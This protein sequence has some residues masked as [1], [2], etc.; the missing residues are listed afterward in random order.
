MIRRF[1][2]GNDLMISATGVQV[3]DT[4]K[5]GQK[6]TIKAKP[7]YIGAL[8]LDSA[9]VRVRDGVAGIDSLRKLRWIQTGMKLDAQWSIPV[10]YSMKPGSHTLNISLDPFRQINLPTGDTTVESLVSNN[11]VSVSWILADT[12]KPVIALDSVVAGALVRRWSPNSD[13]D[14]LIVRGTV[15]LKH[16]YGQLL[17]RWQVRDGAG[18]LL[19]SRDQQSTAS[20][21]V[22]V[23]GRFAPLA[24]LVH[25]N[26]YRL[27]LF[28]QDAFGN[29]DS[30]EVSV[31]ADSSHP[32]LDRWTI[33]HGRGDTAV[34]S[35]SVRK[36]ARSNFNLFDT[37][38][39]QAHD[40]P[41]LLALILYRGSSLNGAQILDTV[42]TAISSSRN[43][44]AVR[45]KDSCV[46]I[47]DAVDLAGNHSRSEVQ[48]LR[49]TQ[50]PFVG[51]WATTRT[52][53]DSM[54]VNDS[55]NPEMIKK[56]PLLITDTTGVRDGSY[57]VNP[58]KARLDRAGAR[59][60]LKP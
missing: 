14:S 28:V 42:V 54:L 18:K 17:V 43:L 31:L 36:L 44:L 16:D 9:I 59:L 15:R 34:G 32:V 12:G 40:N 22:P 26:T 55:L 33:I 25:G 7:S 3:P 58:T 8:K 50:A 23:S 5:I 57:L 30:Q 4:V 51:A 29:R 2:F 35:K 45:Q 19:L 11:L 48:A 10:G 52:M 53:F 27:R 41:G 38:A 21:L 39:G 37:L 24:D 13:A 1:F 6:L 47:L 60:D 46:W 56:R 20:A 49:N